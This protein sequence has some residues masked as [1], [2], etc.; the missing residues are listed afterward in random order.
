MW[1]GFAR[2]FRIR[3][4]LGFTRFDSEQIISYLRKARGYVA[5]VSADLSPVRERALS[6]PALLLQMWSNR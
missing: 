6:K 2:G 3:E 4:K 1:Y 5:D